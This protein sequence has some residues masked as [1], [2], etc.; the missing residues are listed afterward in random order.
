[1]I[2]LFDC[3]NAAKG[4][5]VKSNNRGF[6]KLEKS[7][8]HNTRDIT[9]QRVTSG[10]IHLRGLAPGQHSSEETSQRWRVIGN[11]VSDLTS[12]VIDPQI[13]RTDTTVLNQQT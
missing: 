2:F 9:P 3:Q 6:F 1:M 10:G 4:L 13:S 11:A 12:P 7:N 5:G 8:D